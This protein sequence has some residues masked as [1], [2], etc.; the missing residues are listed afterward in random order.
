VPLVQNNGAKHHAQEFS[1]LVRFMEDEPLRD[2]SDGARAPADTRCP[3][4]VLDDVSVLVLPAFAVRE[5]HR[6]GNPKPV[7]E[8]RLPL[9]REGRRTQNE[10]LAVAK[11]GGHQG[12]ARHRKRFADAHLVG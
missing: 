7:I 6:A 10:H 4:V 5:P 11:K 1:A 12:G 2:D 3:L 9:E 8:F